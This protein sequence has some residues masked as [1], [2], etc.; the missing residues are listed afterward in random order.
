MD[1][2]HNYSD[3]GGQVSGCNNGVVF[4]PWRQN[5][6]NEFDDDDEDDQVFIKREDQHNEVNIGA[7]IEAHVQATAAGR[8]ENNLIAIG[9]DT[10]HYKNDGSSGNSHSSRPVRGMVFSNG[11][12]DPPARR[13]PFSRRSLSPGRSLPPRENPPMRRNPPPVPEYNWPQ[14]TQNV[15]TVLTGDP[16]YDFG[17]YNGSQSSTIAPFP[18]ADTVPAEAESRLDDAEMDR[19]RK[20]VDDVLDDML[21][22]Y[23]NVE[24]RVANNQQQHQQHQQH[25]H[26]RDILRP[27]PPPQHQCRHH[28]CH[29]HHHHHHHHHYH[30][31]PNTTITTISTTTTP[32]TAAAASTTTTTT[33][34]A[35]TNY[36]G[37]HHSPLPHG[38]PSHERVQSPALLFGLPGMTPPQRTYQGNL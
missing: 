38:R 25:Q 21:K 3:A 27:Q 13:D 30:Y 7:S 9:D 23:Y 2:S 34:I 1:P 17:S 6:M 29:H 36:C 18:T 37:Q 32:A 12:R 20:V 19:L 10:S 22:D 26:F 11:V 16:I 28:H 8:S 33:T 35:T 15:D 31:R 5:V 14:T 4:E 24:P